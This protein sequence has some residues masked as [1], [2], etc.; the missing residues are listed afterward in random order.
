MAALP[1]AYHLTSEPSATPRWNEARTIS[2]YDLLRSLPSNT[3]DLV[4]LDPP[5]RGSTTTH[6]NITALISDFTSVA[7][8]CYRVL[9]E[10]GSTALLGGPAVYAA[11]ETAA[12]WSGLTPSVEL[13]VLWDQEPK[14][15]SLRGRR[16]WDIPPN[17]LRP[18]A[19]SIRRHVK[20]GLRLPPATRLTLPSNVLI[21][22]EVPFDQR[23]FPTQR[24]IELFTYI[25]NT[26][27]EPDARIVDPYCGTGSALVAAVS[28]RRTWIGGDVDPHMIEITRRRIQRAK[29]GHEFIYTHPLYWW[30]SGDHRV[31]VEG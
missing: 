7:G 9:R 8:E 27:T 25:L 3:V 22:R 16:G 19:M 5:E 20:P 28:L 30:V 21:C 29:V 15:R 13:T 23:Y 2:A 24:P 11:W 4:V 1:L 12:G 14:H 26:M 17:A 10:G 18:M 6:D 31:L